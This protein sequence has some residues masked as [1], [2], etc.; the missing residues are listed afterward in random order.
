MSG[1]F[2]ITNPASDRHLFPLPRSWQAELAGYRPVRQTAGCSHAA[3]FRLE[4]PDRP[5]LFIKSGKITA[6]GDLAL[7]APRLEWLADAGIPCPRVWARTQEDGRDWLLMSAVAG[8]NLASGS[9]LEPERIVAFAAE[10]LCKMHQLDITRCPFDGRT[11]T[12]IAQARI[13]M[14]AGLVDEDDF[15]EE[16]QGWPAARLFD[17]L[18]SG[19]PDHE[20]LVVAHGDATLENI[21]A[22]DSGFSGFVDCAR[23]GVADRH[24]DLALATRSIEHD[25]GEEWLPVF[26]RHYGMPVVGKKL[27]FF[28]LLDEFF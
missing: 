24:Q 18:V 25:L 16:H 11:S 6:Q 1:G 2:A 17:K 4:A 12:R 19:I 14:E 9:G 20:D 27:A 8:R 26:L 10:G 28:R 7:E 22:D 21:L 15:D 3:V 23:L 13:R 5:A